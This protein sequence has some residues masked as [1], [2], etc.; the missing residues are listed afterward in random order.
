VL[1][2]TIRWNGS[3]S[4]IYLS[5]DVLTVTTTRWSVKKEGSKQ[6]KVY[7]RVVQNYCPFEI[8]PQPEEPGILTVTVTVTVRGFMRANRAD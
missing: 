1:T 4:R 2:V 8:G 3:E 6:D 7:R 5:D